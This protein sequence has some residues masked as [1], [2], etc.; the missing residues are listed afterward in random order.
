M[1]LKIY[2][3]L[4]CLPAFFFFFCAD[5]KA[6]LQPDTLWTRTYGGTNIDVGYCVK[7]TPDNC[8]IITGYTRSF[9]TA[10]GRNVWL[11]KTDRT[12]EMLW[13]KT[14]GGN[15]DDEGASV[16]P[17]ND[18][19]YILTG[20]TSSFGSGLKDLFI[21]KTDSSGIE[22]WSRYFGGS[23]DEEGYSVL[24]LRDGGYIAAGATSSFGAGS[25]DGWLIK[26]TAAGNEVWRK[27]LGGLSSDGLRS[28]QQTS[29]GGFIATG[30]TFSLGPQAVGNAW[31]VK[32][33]SA[34]NQE[35]SKAYGGTDVD[36]GY[37]VQQTRDGG[38]IFTGY[39]ASY[40]AGNDDVLLIKTDN[41]GNQLWMK[42]FGGSGRDYGNSIQLD[43]DGGYIIAGY[44]LSYGAGG[45]DIWLIKTDSSGNMIWNKTYGGTASDV[46]YSVDITGGGGY[47][48]TGHTLSRGAG[49]HDVW[50]IKTGDAVPVELT[51]LSGT[52]VN[53]NVLLRWTTATETNN[54]GF[55]I[56]RQDEHKFTT[57][58]FAA[59]K[60]TTADKTDYS[61][62][63]HSSTG[64]ANKYRLKQIDLTGGVNYSDIIEVK[65]EPAN[66]TLSL[67]VYPN[68]F[69][70]AA[71]INYQI[72]RSA[73]ANDLCSVR[74]IIFDFLGR[75]IA[76]LVNETKSP[77]AYSID[78]PAIII[79]ND[80]GQSLQTG[81]YILQLQAAGQ[82]VV[83]KILLIK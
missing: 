48:I 22:T 73:A 20:Y 7:Q 40:G 16:Q 37:W 43:A 9:G 23:S 72:P 61:Y 51:S 77:G 62:T 82:N 29:D 45:D 30:W 4:I 5:A 41:Q 66:N 55:E 46:G 24:Q 34:G 50:L 79:A 47:V 15:S 76:T 67:D 68:P 65:T 58:G 39:T 3:A 28:V 6:L 69:S 53:G 31:L 14:F 71:T 80:R 33:D 59:G 8:Y 81:I 74:L 52:Y 64:T 27:T 56:Q 38:Y 18:G 13:N 2:S 32:T 11:I 70:S 83:K 78:F 17:A 12:G 10:S 35:W 57:I 25:R 44:T 21:T 49:V 19:G 1:S 75:K 26:V 54:Y 42:T 60:G 63:D 36:R